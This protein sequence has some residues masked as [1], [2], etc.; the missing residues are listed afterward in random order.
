MCFQMV[1]IKKRKVVDFR[2]KII[3]MKMPKTM[4]KIIGKI[5]KMNQE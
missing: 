4:S 3:V 2:M 1:V 5:L